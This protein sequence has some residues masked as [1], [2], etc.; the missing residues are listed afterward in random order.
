LP[1]LLIPHKSKYWLR[2]RL[3]I[4]QNTTLSVHTG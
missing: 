4:L 3:S 1:C 2:Q